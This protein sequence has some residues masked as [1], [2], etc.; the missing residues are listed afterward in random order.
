[1]ERF[2]NNK[3]C[4]IF[5]PALLGLGGSMLS[6]RVF[7]QY[8]WSLF[9]GL[10]IIVSFLSAFAWSFKRQRSFGSAYGV[11]TL[12]IF[13]LGGFILIFALDGLVCLLMALAPG[14]LACSHRC[15]CWT[16]V[17][18]GLGIQ[19]RCDSIGSTL[20]DLSFASRV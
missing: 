13:A 4:A 9:L 15:R 1:M 3:L 14:T 5:V 16:F 20:R 6:V 11:A 10:P 2:L 8:G 17:G 7:E 18:R 12:S 19:Q